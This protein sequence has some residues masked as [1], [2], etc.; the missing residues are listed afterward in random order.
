MPSLFC[1]FTIHSSSVSRLSLYPPYKEMMTRYLC[2]RCA[3]FTQ[4][5]HF[6]AAAPI[7]HHTTF[8][9]RNKTPHFLLIVKGDSAIFHQT[10]RFCCL[11]LLILGPLQWP[12]RVRRGKTSYWIAL[13]TKLIHCVFLIALQ[14]SWAHHC[15]LPQMLQG[16]GKPP[17][18][19]DLGLQTTLPDHPRQCQPPQH[20]E[21]IAA[22]G[23]LCGQPAPRAWHSW[24]DLGWCC[25]CCHS[26]HQSITT[27]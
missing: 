9:A 17:S 26:P 27:G 4:H 13:N 3:N 18:T 14:D 20:D 1:H 6:T 2:I 25:L 21:G 5:P 12:V 22:E 11:F 15:P 19:P 16:S 10:L 7:I 8:A 23:V 24:V